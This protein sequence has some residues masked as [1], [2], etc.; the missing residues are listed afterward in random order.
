[1]G[2]DSDQKIFIGSTPGGIYISD[3]GERSIVHD[4]SSE[5]RETHK[6]DGMIL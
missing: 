2:H 6:E 1:M 4:V 5:E 3:R